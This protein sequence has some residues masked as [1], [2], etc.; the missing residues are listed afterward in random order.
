MIEYRDGQDAW[1]ATPLADSLAL[2]SMDIVPAPIRS[3]YLVLVNGQRIPGAAISNPDP[4]E[5]VVVWN[6]PWLGRMNVPLTQVE[7]VVFKAGVEPPAA[8]QTDVVLLGNG[9][10]W[11][12][13]VTALAD[14]ITIAVETDGELHDVLIP[15]SRAVAVTMVA[16]RQDPRGRRVWLRDGTVLDVE[17]I[18]LGADR[19]VRLAGTLSAGGGS[20]VEVQLD[21]VVAIRFD[22]DRMRPLS[23]LKPTRV[24]GPITRF[25]LPRPRTL[26]PDAPLD[27]GRVSY[28]GPIVV[29]YA[30]PIG[31]RRFAAVAALPESARDWGDVVLVIRDNDTEV[32]RVRLN[33]SRPAA[34]I[35]VA[36]SGAELTIELEPGRRGPIQDRVTLERA[37]LLVDG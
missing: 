2:L 29:R 3:G 1:A 13:F 18:V 33:G 25:E 22:P 8:A 21:D 19:Y 7:S 5:E 10:R 37:M 9:D 27:L 12:G 31:C 30:L 26:D 28:R 32:F 4:A 14:P 17:S 6:H 23:A 24:E 20:E 16:P 36:L 15:L 34:P 11:E 35:N